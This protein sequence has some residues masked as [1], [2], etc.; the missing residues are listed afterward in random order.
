[1]T[2][3]KTVLKEQDDEAAT[4]E[5]ISYEM[6]EGER[7]QKRL[8]EAILFASTQ[9][10]S[11]VDLAKRLPK[12]ADIHAILDDLTKFYQQ[13]G[14]VLEQN[15]SYFAFRTAPD[16][17]YYLSG[18]SHVARK[19]SRVALE[20]LAIIAY[21]Q[22]VSRAEIED[23]RG[24][25]VS[26]GTLNLL[27]EADWIAPKGRRAAPGRPMVWGTT[28]SFLDH[29]GLASLEALPGIEE[30]RHAGLLDTLPAMQQLREQVEETAKEPQDH[31]NYE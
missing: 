27:L 9:P 14:V 30:L 5:I 10:V 24:V 8:V 12:G 22:P 20:T 16:L 11:Q 15:G 3:D 7:D 28:P 17:K 18:E 23:I 13:R 29:F 4:S 21:H 19:L 25:T 31:T 6:P 1:M 2:Q 26:R